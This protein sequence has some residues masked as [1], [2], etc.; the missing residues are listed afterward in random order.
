MIDIIVKYLLLAQACIVIFWSATLAW[1][2]FFGIIANK[3][4]K[5]DLEQE[6]IDKCFNK[7]KVKPGETL[8]IKY[9]NGTIV[10]MQRPE[11]EN[12]R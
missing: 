2:W 5:R 9:K 7:R 11:V 1:E 3:V 12:E 4:F 6:A 8:V 10:T